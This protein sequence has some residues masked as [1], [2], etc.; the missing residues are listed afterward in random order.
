M[1]DGTTGHHASGVD[2][3]LHDWQAGS[4]PD[5]LRESEVHLWRV[6]LRRPPEGVDTF[7]QL[8]SESE[9][10]RCDAIR[11]PQ[12]RASYC[13]CHGYLRMLL[14][15]YGCGKPD[16]IRIAI[17]EYG[18]PAIDPTQHDIGI[19]FS[20]SHSGGVALIALARSRQV[21]VDVQEFLSSVPTGDISRRFFS[22]QEYESIRLQPKDS[23]VAAF[24]SCWARKEAAIKALG[25]SIARLSSEVIVS[26]D[27]GEP[28]QLLRMPPGENSHGWRLQ[29]LPVGEGYA[30]ALCYLGPG[31]L[32][33]LWRPPPRAT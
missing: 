1:S 22:P 17:G 24:Y 33:R 30:G 4:G 21:G 3:A 23:R 2:E 5:A 26:T 32:V 7:R 10:R 12:E 11:V 14:A 15:R 27:P 19:D 20:L 6:D 16:E 29:D 13:I 31:T 9:K 18:K 8:L 25:G 28:A